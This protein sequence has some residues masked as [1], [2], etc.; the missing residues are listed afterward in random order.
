MLLMKWDLR[1]MRE[2]LNSKNYF[3]RFWLAYMVG[4]LIASL[5]FTAIE[6]LTFTTFLRKI[7]PHA[8][9]GTFGLIVIFLLLR[10][11]RFE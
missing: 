4:T 3:K 7:L 2:R 9:G 6:G 5:F 1:K 10:D 11:K 8:V